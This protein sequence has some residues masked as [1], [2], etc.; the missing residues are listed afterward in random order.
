MEYLDFELELGSGQGPNYPVS[1]RSPAG[2][3]QGTM[4]FPFSELQLENQLQSLEIALLESDGRQ[5]G[6]RRRSLSPDQMRVQAF[7]QV[8][9]EALFT[10]DVRSLFD[11]SREEAR[12]EGKGLRLQ[13]RILCPE[14]AA[15]PWEFLYDQRE[16]EYISLSTT[17]PIVRYPEILQPL[18][19]LTVSPPLRI[20][21][22]AVSPT[23]LE[24]LDIANEQQRVNRAL[25][26]LHSEG[27]VEL[28]WLTGQTWG[29]L[30]RAMLREGPWHVFHFIGHGGFDPHSDEGLIALADETGKAHLLPA[31]QLAQVLSDHFPLRL[32]FLNSC[33]GA[34]GSRLDI[35]SSTAA[36]LVRRN[37]AAVVAMQYEISDQA[38]IDFSRSF[39]TNIA[40]GTPVDVAVAAGRQAISA[41]APTTLEWGTPVL[42]MHSRDGRLFDI[43]L[44]PPVS[45]ERQLSQH[46]D[47]ARQALE[48]HDWPKAIAELEVVRRI[49]AGYRDVQ[50]RL[51]EAERQQGLA[52]LYDE[53]RRLY[54]AGDWPEVVAIF[55]RI[56][57]I[58]P[59]YPDP[60]GLLRSVRDRLQA[61]QA[62]DARQHDL[63]ARYAQALTEL[64]AEHWPAAV[65]LLEQIVAE[66][67]D[68]RDAASKLREAQQ[69]QLKQPYAEAAQDAQRFRYDAYI[70]YVDREPDASWVWE[71][72]VPRLVQGGLRIAVSGDVK[73]PG[74][75]QVV[76]IERGIK[77]AKRTVIVLS[78]AYLVDHYADFENVLAQTMGIQEGTYRLLPVKIEP[79]DDCRLP[80]R[81]NMLT[82][83]DLAH[84]HRASREFDRL[85]QAL[86]GPLPG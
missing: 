29:D 7:G 81:L 59:A 47:A 10:G 68:Y 30:Q 51:T 69:R 77:Q 11:V 5:F 62:E 3:I 60:E 24:P 37:I 41:Y 83:L 35:F 6:T 27:L 21:G 76:G 64:E 17:T 34:R 63:A 19:P 38:A 23:D 54:Q 22:M 70:S 84:P 58:D 79:I 57:A 8:L 15:L 40:A 39:Y 43:T 1:V 53:A 65:R 32:V 33:E 16:G 20:L 85:V 18:R 46:Y 72:L 82:T 74:V 49:N 25:A 36:T 66:Q 14:L 13:L 26:D 75:A 4:R 71:T 55:A 28:T 50:A 2:E 80:L 78:E 31:R 73:E 42:Y 56:K 45:G 61:Q 9:F 52:E 12:N 48:A 86:R 44:R 67:P